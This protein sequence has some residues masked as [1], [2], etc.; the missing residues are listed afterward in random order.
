M[1]QRTFE[2]FVRRASDLLDRRSLLGGLSAALLSAGIV[3]LDTEAKKGNKGKKKTKACKKRVK[4][5][6]NEV[7]P[8]CQGN[9]DPD[10][11][12]IVRNCCKKACKSHDKA[13][14]CLEENF[15]G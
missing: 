12:G 14:A 6:H 7:L 3:P 4:I 11:E 13:D 1:D 2:T 5:C 10:C 9:P 15:P 8:Q